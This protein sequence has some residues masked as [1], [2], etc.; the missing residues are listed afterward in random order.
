MAKLGSAPRRSKIKM[1][2]RI[3]PSGMASLLLSIK[4]GNS[5]LFVRRIGNFVGCVLH[6]LFRVTGELFSLAFRLLSEALGFQLFRVG[7][8]TARVR[9]SGR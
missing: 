5:E 9:N 4:P 8:F 3:V 7:G 2:S 1:M 6:R